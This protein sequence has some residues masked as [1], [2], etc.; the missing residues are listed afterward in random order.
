MCRQVPISPDEEV[1]GKLIES[2]TM[3]VFLKASPFSS[4]QR[5]RLDFTMT[6]DF[7]FEHLYCHSPKAEQYLADICRRI[8]R[9][10]SKNIILYGYQGCGKT[11]FVHYML[12]KLNCRSVL[13]NFDAYVDNG[14]EIKHEL[15]AHL[16]RSIMHDLTGRDGDD[17]LYPLGGRIGATAQMFCEV[18]NS[19]ENKRIIEE[20]YDSWNDYVYFFDKLEYTKLLYTS[21]AEQLGMSWEEY[22]TKKDHY[23][24][25]DLKVHIAQ[26]DINQLMVAIVLWDIAYTLAFEK[27]DQC[28]IVFESL[29]TIF[30]AAALPDFTKQ[31]IYFRNNIDSILADLKY[32]GTSLAMMNR[33]Y[34][35]I[36]VMRETTKC[37][38]VDHFVDS[39]EMYIPQQ[40][41]SFLYEYKDVVHHRNLYLHK[42]K[43]YRKTRDEDV[44]GITKLEKELTQLENL[45][46]DPYI[47]ERMFGLF[48][49]NFRV[50][51][52]IL[53]EIAF[54]VPN[55][56]SDAVR[57]KNLD[58]TDRWSPKYASR[59]VLFR[60]FFNQ[61]SME[62]YFESLKKSEY[63]IEVK[64][65]HYSVNLSRYILLYL[66]NKQGITRRDE[67]KENQMVSLQELF[68]DL[69]GVCDDKKLIVNSLWNMYEMRKKPFW[70]H[71]ITFDDML[72]L[73]PNVLE[74]QLTWVIENKT[75]EKFGKVRIT[76]AGVTYLDLLLPHFEY[77]AARHFKS[78]AKSFFAYSLD[79]FFET[80]LD[81][82]EQP[83]VVALADVWAEVKDCFYR[84]S[85]FYKAELKD[86]EEYS[87]T[88]F[89]NSNFAWKKMSRNTGIITKM[90]HGER[91]IHSHIGYLD[92]LRFYCFRIVDASAN[93]K[94]T[95]INLDL[96]TPLQK[97]MS[98]NGVEEYIPTIAQIYED[99]INHFYLHSPDCQLSGYTD[100]F[101]EV[102]S[103]YRDGNHVLQHIP[104]QEMAIFLKA[105]LNI[106]IIDAIKQYIKLVKP[107]HEG[108]F[109]AVSDDSFYLVSCYMACI[110]EKIEKKSYT[111]FETSI[112]R[113]TGDELLRSQLADKVDN[114]TSDNWSQWLEENGLWANS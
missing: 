60:Q 46:E 7:F 39:V 76:T 23:P 48:N 61:F 72:T 100:D 5:S 8:D 111:D 81:Q 78:Y 47:K 11:T 12:Q 6:A 31:I 25:T 99:A 93:H 57:V 98:I 104:V 96:C 86:V 67:D 64:R 37:E 22:E 49:R 27:Q 34:T 29:D 103:V 105:Y 51:T 9:E 41:M 2:T 65:K 32:N 10:S 107:E 50:C 73:N 30:N 75:D 28:C 91:L 17:G 3:D 95:D 87:P 54:M 90:F 43:S 59:C 16:Y 79:E 112:C 88:N 66:N 40:S 84:L 74:Q 24:V 45:M 68:K 70:G 69:L 62:G 102:E 56:F 44:T 36:F 108:D 82:P 58:K 18:F 92:T 97:V 89:L 20:K 1:I 42:L 21:T 101:Q 55:T 35:L 109:V 94:Q 71:L 13:I 33:L 85:Q 114:F 38:F 63:H 26:L 4:G 80:T 52:R 113:E 19:H 53:S 83:L 110:C 77:F 106:T 15:V 14:N